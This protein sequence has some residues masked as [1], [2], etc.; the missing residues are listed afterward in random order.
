M[1]KFTSK[2]EIEAVQIT[3]GMV[4]GTEPLPHKGISR[5][6]GM[7]VVGMYVPRP[8]IEVETEYD[9]TL[10]AGVGDWVVTH[11]QGRY[12]TYELFANDNFVAAYGAVAASKDSAEDRL[13]D[14]L[15]N[16]TW[17]QEY[18]RVRQE[19]LRKVLEAFSTDAVPGEIP[20]LTRDGKMAVVYSQYSH[21]GWS[22]QKGCGQYAEELCVRRDIAQAV[23]DGKNGDAATLVSQTIRQYI[24]TDEAF[25]LE[26][27]WVTIGT[28]FRIDRRDGTETVV[29]FAE[30]IYNNYYVAR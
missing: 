8:H 18:I 6:K 17:H 26:I 5:Y 16:T 14:V 12:D 19:D 10:E 30:D 27:R 22:T 15:R 7:Y 4:D 2:V 29:E 9:A 20:T 3:Q 13:R 11:N 24:N 28:P 25:E 21:D 1:A 23:L